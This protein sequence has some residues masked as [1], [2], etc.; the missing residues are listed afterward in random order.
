MRFKLHLASCSRREVNL[1]KKVEDKLSVL[2]VGEVEALDVD[3]DTAWREGQHMS[4]RVFALKSGADIHATVSNMD[5]SAVC[6]DDAFS[7]DH[8]RRR[9]GRKR[10]QRFSLGAIEKEDVIS[11]LP[12]H[13]FAAIRLFLYEQC[14]SFRLDHQLILVFM[15][16]RE[17]LSIDCDR[18]SEPERKGGNQWL[19]RPLSLEIPYEWNTKTLSEAFDLALKDRSLSETEKVAIWKDLIL[20]RKFGDESNEGG[21]R[22]PT[23]VKRHISSEDLMESLLENANLSCSVDDAL[24]SLA[25]RKGTMVRRRERGFQG[26]LLSSLTKMNEPKS[27]CITEGE[28][29]FVKGGRDQ[30]HT[31]K[32]IH[33]DFLLSDDEDNT[34]VNNYENLRLSSPSNDLMQTAKATGRPDFFSNQNS[35]TPH[36]SY[37]DI[38]ETVLSALALSGMEVEIDI[39]NE[40]IDW[41][42]TADPFTDSVRDIADAAFAKCMQHC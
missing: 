26:T 8:V 2:Q 12:T 36:P 13:N 20:L 30:G 41:A 10:T 4:M 23:Q 18:N 19:P 17:A 15:K 9:S 24:G 34:K 28:N 27:D 1:P 16:L 22:K 32:V 38:M 35:S 3:V 21:R 5:D 37:G 31:Y 6:T 14:P 33:N 42:R 11:V 29:S 25:N 39:V 7:A 40:A